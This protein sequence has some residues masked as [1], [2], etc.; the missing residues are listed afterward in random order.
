MGSWYKRFRKLLSPSVR[1]VEMRLKMVWYNLH[2]PCIVKRI[3]GKDRVRV[4]FFV[5]NLSMW[6]CDSLFR[7]LLSDS[8]FDPVMVL[9]PR[10]MFNYDAEKEE[11]L[12]LMDYCRQMGYPFIPGYDYEREQF[13]GADE[14]RPDLVFFSQPYNDAYPAHKLEAY[15]KNS[16]FFYI[17][18]CIMIEEQSVMINTLFMNICQTV[19]TENDALRSIESR[20][21]SNRGKNCMTS[22]FI[23]ERELTESPVESDYSLW[24]EQSKE[25]KRVIWAPHHSI[26]AKDKLNYSNFLTIADDMVQLASDYKGRVQF[27]FKPHPGLKPKLYDMEGWG[28]DRTDR[29]YSLW[30]DM[31]NTSV[32]EGTYQGLF[33]SSDAM[34][35]DCSSFT[36]E[37][38]YTGKPVMYITKEDHLDFMNAFGTECYD[39]HYKGNGIDDIRSFIDKVVIGGDDDMKAARDSFVRENLTHSSQGYAD[40]IIMNCL[41]TTVGGGNK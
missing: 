15:W 27:V 5:V 31:P 24:K 39:M 37:Y 11:Q 9:M 33:R 29:Y 14:I 23:G 35:H 40:E 34:I 10:P 6:K 26:L 16:L 1:Y 32:V 30:N 28:K 7:L 20:I 21:L 19:F 13:N 2:R 22:G 4:A 36:A 3:Q 18:Y 17:P 12:R 38:L 41:I 25:I 8:R